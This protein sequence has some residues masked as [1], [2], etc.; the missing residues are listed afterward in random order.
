MPLTVGGLDDAYNKVSILLTLGLWP[1]TCIFLSN[2]TS[3]R[4]AWT[5]HTQLDFVGGLN[6]QWVAG[7][8]RPKCVCLGGLY[9]SKPKCKNCFIT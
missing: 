6:L 7:G 9:M 4:P 3:L 2:Y 1:V 5:L 8:S